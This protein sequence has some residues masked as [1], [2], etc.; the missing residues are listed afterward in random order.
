VKGTERETAS[1]RSAGG[2]FSA[3]VLAICRGVLSGVGRTALGMVSGELGP[4]RN[5]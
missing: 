3:L 1:D 5:R 2:K 4:W